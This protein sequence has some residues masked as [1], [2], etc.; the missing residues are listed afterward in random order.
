M[1]PIDHQALLAESLKNL[2]DSERWLKRSYQICKTIS[3]KANYTPTE[4][5]RHD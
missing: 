4:F 3:I 1:T 5:L 2:D